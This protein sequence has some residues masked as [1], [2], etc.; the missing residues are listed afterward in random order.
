MPPRRRTLATPRAVGEPPKA[1]RP[2]PC[3]PRPLYRL[4]REVADA[5]ESRVAEEWSRVLDDLPTPFVALQ[6]PATLKS[7]VSYLAKCARVRQTRRYMKGIVR[8]PRFGGS[9]RGPRSTGAGSSWWTSCNPRNPPSRSDVG[10]KVP[11]SRASERHI[12]ADK[13]LTRAR[14]DRR[15]EARAVADRKCRARPGRRAKGAGRPARLVAEPEL[16]KSARSA[17]SVL[18]TLRGDL[19]WKAKHRQC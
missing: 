9:S 16:P 3:V 6:S 11:R 14:T 5:D 8:E 17:T 18:A 7:D 13:L 10:A 1:D 4:A 15:S 19:E 12:A 2:A